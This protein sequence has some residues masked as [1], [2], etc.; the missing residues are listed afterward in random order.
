MLYICVRAVEHDIDFD[1][2]MKVL[3]QALARNCLPGAQRVDAGAAL[4]VGAQADDDAF[5]VVTRFLANYELIRKQFT[6]L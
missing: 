1:L 2:F 4:H 3:R 6:G 5:L